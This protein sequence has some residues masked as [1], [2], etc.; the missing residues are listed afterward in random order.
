V[1]VTVRRTD[2]GFAV[3]DDGPGIPAD[4][5]EAIFDVGYLTNEDGTGFGLNIVRSIV[6]AHGWD[7][8]VGESHPTAP[9]S[10]FSGVERV[11]SETGPT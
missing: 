8:T 4:H 6:D 11:E 9:A 10:E 2:S 5:R 7:V 1:T 3:E